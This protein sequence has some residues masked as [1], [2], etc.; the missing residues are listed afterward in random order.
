M[1]NELI[2]YTVGKLRKGDR[3]LLTIAICEDEPHM[4][5]ELK[6]K[7]GGYL[8][9]RAID[10]QIL[11]FSSAISL[12]R[13]D[14]IFDVILMDIKMDGLDGMEAV[15]RLRTKGA[16]SQVIFATSCKEFVFQ[17][18]DVDAVHYL[19]KPISN[20][21]L[22]RALF[23]AIKRCNQVDVQTITVRKGA[24]TQ[25]IPF[26]DI[27]YCEAIGHKI[28][29]CTKNGKVDCYSKLGALQ[30]LLDERF[31]RCHRSYLVNMNF[32]S[33]KEG[34]TAIMINGDSVLVSRRK[35][36]QFSQQLLSCI[37]SEVL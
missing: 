23:K 7:I 13:A 29:I 18:F 22:S 10:G 17:A 2:S 1:E 32:V 35:Q 12:L 6:I 36:Q 27:L 11:C 15:R 3:I 34:D 5:Q 9:Q 28:Y 8:S 26:R 19:V 20:K 16:C 30:D 24:S 21:D 33:G 31:F 37:R 25:V 14:Q 4:S